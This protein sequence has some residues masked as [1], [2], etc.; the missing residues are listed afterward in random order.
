MRAS[1]PRKAHSS[2]A[3]AAATKAADRRAEEKLR[4]RLRRAALRAFRNFARRLAV[5][6]T[7]GEAWSGE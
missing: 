7:G 4:A 1:D 3:P 2:A 5:G 6:R